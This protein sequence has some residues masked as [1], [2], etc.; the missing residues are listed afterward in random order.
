MRHALP[1]LR[2]R[3]GATP[4][5]LIPRDWLILRHCGGL[6]LDADQMTLTER[7]TGID[8]ST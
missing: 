2:R 3:F 1:P 4:T 7:S 6:R 5:L 8:P